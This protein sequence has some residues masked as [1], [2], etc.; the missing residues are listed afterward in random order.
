MWDP[1]EVSLRLSLLFFSA[2]LFA[3]RIP[4]STLQM[5]CL[6]K[7]FVGRRRLRRYDLSWESCYL[8]VS[9]L[10][11]PIPELLIYRGKEDSVAGHSFIGFPVVLQ[12]YLQDFFVEL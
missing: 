11:R 3:L 4:A 5:N 1:I 10:Q 12:K 9:A 7:T 2:S 8:R 6:S